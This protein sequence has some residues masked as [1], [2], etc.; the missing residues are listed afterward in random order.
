MNF[1]PKVVTE[2]LISLSSTPRDR[3]AILSNIIVGLNCLVVCVCSIEFIFLLC[4][5]KLEQI[6]DI[7]GPV[8]QVVFVVVVE[9]EP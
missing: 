6:R 3:V 2:A 8:D 4:N 5:Q 9:V 7:E 1:Q